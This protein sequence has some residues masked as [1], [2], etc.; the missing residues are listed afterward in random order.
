MKLTELAVGKSGVIT[1]VAGGGMQRRRLLDLGF[2]PGSRVENVR[3][4]PT[5]N[6]TAYLIKGTL[7]ALRREESDMLFVKML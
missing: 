1:S 5:G 6:P 4:S 2:I 3:C 7:I